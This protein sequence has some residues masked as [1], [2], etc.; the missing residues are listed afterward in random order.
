MKKYL[1]SLFSFFFVVPSTWAASLFTESSVILDQY[2]TLPVAPM[3]ITS[4]SMDDI[5]AAHGIRIMLDPERQILWNAGEIF[6]SGTAVSNGKVDLNAASYS[7]DYKSVFIP[8]KQDFALNETLKLTG[9]SLRAYKKSFDYQY[10]KLD[11][12]GDMIADVTD[13]N[14]YK[15]TTT[16]KTDKTAPYSV[17]GASYVINADQTLTLNW[18][19]PPDYDYFQT[20][21][22]RIEV[23]NGF[24]SNVLLE[25]SFGDTYQDQTVKLDA[26]ESLIY[27]ISAIDTNGNWSEPVE[28]KVNLATSDQTP[29][30]DQPTENPSDT[31]DQNDPWVKKLESLI[32]YF[33]LRFEVDCNSDLASDYSCLWARIRLIHAQELT[34]LY[35]V[36]TLK[37]SQGDLDQMSFR[38]KWPELRYKETCTGLEDEPQC[39][40]LKEDL[41]RLSYFLD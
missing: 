28:I 41:D 30:T 37:L 14:G 40:R 38:R 19:N 11:L 16:I 6:L 35:V 4:T 17:N 21:V 3:T 18:K 39:V 1:I 34:E 20:A 29:A 10:F 32:K 9:L 12:D 22:Q 23:E 27:K 7:E 31:V 33:Y 26:L 36:P 2:E 8:V 13:I 5:T 25:Q 24:E 15:V